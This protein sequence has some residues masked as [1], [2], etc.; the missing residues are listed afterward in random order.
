MDG[1]DI[2]VFTVRTP[3][4]FRN[5][6]SL[7]APEVVTARGLREQEIVG[8]VLPGGDT[9]EGLDPESF[10]QNPKFVELIH[11]VVSRN[12]LDQEEGRA[13]AQRIGKGWVWILD[14][15]TATPEGDVPSEDIIG[16]FEVQD[17]EFVPGG[18]QPNPEYRLFT[19]RGFF[20][21]GPALPLLLEE[22]EG[23]N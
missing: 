6:V 19:S 17:G 22:L 5:L 4:G 9:K 11:A 20:Q 12:A 13:E 2:Y 16:G 10:L 7:V 23:G 21:L 14:Q 8:E 15:R 1:P 3:D 18:Y